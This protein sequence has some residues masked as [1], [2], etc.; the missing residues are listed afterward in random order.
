MVMAMIA[1]K[2]L[3]FAAL[4]NKSY[5]SYETGTHCPICLKFGRS[6]KVHMQYD[7]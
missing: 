1:D 6:D 2:Y 4:K 5:F 3:S 7:L